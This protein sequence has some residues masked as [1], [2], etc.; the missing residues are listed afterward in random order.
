MPVKVLSVFGTRPDA[1]KMCPLVLELSKDPRFQSIVCVSAQHREM[2][3]TVL[4]IFHVKPDYDLNVMK[5]SQTLFEITNAV[6]SG[7]SEVLDDCRP[8]IVLVHGDTSTAFVSALAAFYKQIPVGH[9]EAG[10]R[11]G[12][13]YAPF[14][15]EANRTL[16]GRLA[17]LNFA[18]TT[19]NRQNLLDEKCPGEIF[20]TGNTVIDAM[21]YTTT[22]QHTYTDPALR[23]VA[24]KEGV[25]PVFMTAHRRENLGK[26]LEDICRAARAFVDAVPEAELVY[27]VHLNPAVRSTVY[28]IL[29]G[30]PRIHLTDPVDLL[31][32]HNFMARCRFV[33]TD[34]GGIQE[35]A[36]ALGVPTLVLRRETERG[37]GVETGILK[38][39]GVDYDEILASCV[40]LCRDDAVHQRMSHAENPYGDGHACERIADA[41]A[42]YFEKK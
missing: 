1:I 39:V 18:P 33:L 31:D 37:E 8:D 13:I 24:A 27:A 35:E 38:L 4:D 20:V 14:P 16:I 9:V 28:P 32:A 30:H 23:E 40:E 3:D 25:M 21:R 15:E 41:M 17:E 34:S 19:Q 26:P 29:S 11:T 5:P 6:L 36:T 10:L 12:N 22:E 42:A 2:L 7:L